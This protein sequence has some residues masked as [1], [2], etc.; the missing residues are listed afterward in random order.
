MCHNVFRIRTYPAR[1]WLEYPW[2][3]RGD[4]PLVRPSRCA[5]KMTTRTIR[6]WCSRWRKLLGKPRRW[7]AS[8]QCRAE[9]WQR[10]AHSEKTWAFSSSNKKNN[11]ITNLKVE[12]ASDCTQYTRM[13]EVC[14][15]ILNQRAPC[16]CTCALVN[17]DINK[18]DVCMKKS[19]TLTLNLWLIA[20]RYAQTERV[21]I[22]R[23]IAWMIVAT[24][25]KR[26][27][28]IISW[29]CSPNECRL[30]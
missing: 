2:I 20:G 11:E 21:T 19:R 12:H 13:Y 7:V 16:T 25:V 3:W 29:K 18:Q 1:R 24:N 4:R 30:Q 6:T 5:N 15:E 8:G 17:R 10:P 23:H 27:W 28:G 26:V 22:C 14:F 9:T